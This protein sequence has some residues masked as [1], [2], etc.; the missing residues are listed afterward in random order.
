MDFIPE[1]D[2]QVTF[3][4]SLLIVT[5][6][7]LEQIASIKKEREKRQVTSSKTFLA[8]VFKTLEPITNKQAHEVT[9]RIVADK[10]YEPKLISSRYIVERVEYGKKS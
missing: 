9:I 8:D 4:A 3:P 5:T 1:G 6:S 10:W 7:Y 2:D